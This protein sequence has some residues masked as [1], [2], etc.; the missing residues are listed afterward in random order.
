[1]PEEFEVGTGRGVGVWLRDMSPSSL[2]GSPAYPWKRTPRWEVS[3]ARTNARVDERRRRR[4]EDFADLQ[5]GKPT[6]CL[7]TA[8]T[9]L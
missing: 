9:N 4:I 8:D 3:I 6:L 7:R 5:N 1:M 2:L